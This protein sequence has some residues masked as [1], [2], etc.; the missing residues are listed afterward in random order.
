MMFLLGIWGVGTEENVVGE[1]DKLISKFLT[2]SLP[3]SCL[4]GGGEVGLRL[5]SL[6]SSSTEQA[7]VAQRELFITSHGGAIGAEADARA[8]RELYH[9]L[10]PGPVDV[11]LRVA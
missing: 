9:H 2:F 10:G 8:R 6:E 3:A 11:R 7:D 4:R 1:V 5:F